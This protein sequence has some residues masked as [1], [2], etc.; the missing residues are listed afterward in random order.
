MFNDEGNVRLNI[1]KRELK[2]IVETCDLET[3]IR[4]P[5]AQRRAADRAQAAAAERYG[6]HV[7]YPRQPTGTGTGRINRARADGRRV[8]V[9][10]S[11][12]PLRRIKR[13]PSGSEGRGSSA[14]QDREDTDTDTD[15][16]GPYYSRLDDFNPKPLLNKL[17][18]TDWSKVQLPP[19]PPMRMPALKPIAIPRVI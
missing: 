19:M 18:Q 12:T 8:V 7:P 4:A 3:G 2:T 13:P 16:N 14:T 5:E 1:P 10:D 15:T 6:Q 17:V 11:D 9:Q